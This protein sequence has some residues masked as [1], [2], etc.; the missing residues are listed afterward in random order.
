MTER[1]TRPPASATSPTLPFVE[2]RETLA[3][4]LATA[5]T[6]MNLSQDQLAERASI[7]RATVIQIES[8]E[9]DPRLSTVV[10]L[11]ST[12]GV[13]AVFLLL[14]ASELNALVDVG[15]GELVPRVE[16][17][18][19]EDELETMRRLIRS[20]LAKNRTR[21]VKIGTDATIAAGFVAV[22]AIVGAAIGS[23]LLPGIG[24]A[25]LAA[26]GSRWVRHETPEDESA[27]TPEPI[28]RRPQ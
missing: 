19:R 8:G 27:H 9:S 26:L 4:N 28:R 13:P 15:R 24:T 25:F 23:A 7:S 18:L 1:P 17:Y 12:L 16:G 11:A 20:G 14:G 2:A 3:R 5:R 10:N 22:G 21:A 6:A